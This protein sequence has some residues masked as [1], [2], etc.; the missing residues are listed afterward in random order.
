MALELF[1]R[2]RHTALRG[3]GS[4]SRIPANPQLWIVGFTLLTL[5]VSLGISWS[6]AKEFRHE[7]QLLR[8]KVSNLEKAREI[9]SIALNRYRNSI[10]YIVGTY[11]ISFPHEPSVRRTRI[12]GTG[13]VVDN[14]LIATNRHVAQP[15]FKEPDSEALI[16][17]GGIP[18]LEDLV[19]YFPGVALPIPLKTVAL[20]QIDDVAVVAMHS[21]LKLESIPLSSAKPGTGDSVAVLG[22][23]MGLLGMMAKS[24]SQVYARL[25]PRQ[26]SQNSAK[27]LAALSLIRPSATF[28][29][30][31]DIIGEKL[32]YDAA[33]AKGASGGPV[34]NAEGEVIGVN[35]GYI[36]GFSGGT[37]GVSSQVL[38]PLIMQAKSGAGRRG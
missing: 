29:H 14:G 37:I 11:R 16:H 24:P 12:S 3:A 4:S 26:D 17:L 5:S 33:T 19:A 20:S 15:W 32:I 2:E 30:L 6:E 38:K 18:T 8:E 10:C 21:E 36:D 23:P 22:Y 9:P 31:G 25:A 34:F 27:E 13:F 35:Q 7:I 28:G 1:F